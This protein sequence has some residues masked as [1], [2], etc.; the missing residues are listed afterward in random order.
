MTGS[1][2]GLAT[3]LKRDYPLLFTIHCQAHWLELAVNNA[4]D[5]VTSMSHLCSFVDSLYSLYS[6]STKNQYELEAIS[7]EVGVQ[8]LRVNKIFDV[9]WFFS[10][11]GAIR[12]LW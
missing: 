8:L 3:L 12:A 4:V 2:N 10:T 1:R 11:Y 7:Q 6:R 9:R 5:S